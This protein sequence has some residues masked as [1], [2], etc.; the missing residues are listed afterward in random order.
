MG[1]AE[2]GHFLCTK[3]TVCVWCHTAR[4]GTSSVLGGSESPGRAGSRGV[5]WPRE[6]E[7]RHREPRFFS[8]STQACVAHA[9]LPLKRRLGNA[10]LQDVLLKRCHFGTRAQGCKCPAPASHTSSMWPA[11]SSCR[12]LGL[13]LPPGVQTPFCP[14][15]MTS[16][17]QE[18]ST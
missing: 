18:S 9:R 3:S 4:R 11:V 7:Q 2:A 10:F 13:C 8:V 1:P 6:R 17:P 15:Q 5:G 16:R 14:V 12:L